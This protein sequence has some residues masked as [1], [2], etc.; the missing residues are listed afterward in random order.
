MYVVTVRL[1]LKSGAGGALRVWFR[2]PPERREPNKVAELH[3]ERH[4]AA[5]GCRVTTAKWRQPKKCELPK[6]SRS[7]KA[8]VARPQR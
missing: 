3:R 4:R 8:V 2:L 7:G 1:E 6:L 5:E